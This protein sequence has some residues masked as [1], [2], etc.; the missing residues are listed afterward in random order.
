[1][2]KDNIIQFPTKHKPSKKTK[3]EVYTLR[4]KELEVENEYLNSD[5][6]YLSSQ[7]ETNLNECEVLLHKMREIHETTIREQAAELKN[8]FGVDLTK[9]VEELIDHDN[10]ED[11]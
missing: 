9:L 1:M 5:I 3:L 8:D 2:S 4:L 11:K 7:L 6:D 10:P